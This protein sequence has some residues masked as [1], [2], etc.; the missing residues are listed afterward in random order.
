MSNYKTKVCQV[1]GK[2][3]R[4]TNGNQKYCTECGP[5]VDKS[6]FA[7]WCKAN[8]EKVKVENAKYYRLHGDKKKAWAIEYREANP[9][10]M[11]ER[12]SKYNK[13]NPDG[14]KEARTK[15]CEANPEKVKAK[16]AKHGAKRRDLAFLSLNSWFTGSDG[17]HLDADHVLFI[18]HMLHQSVSHNHRTGHG[19]EQINALAYAYAGLSSDIIND[20]LPFD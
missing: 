7:K 16:D 19:M 18:P 3:Y 5:M 4:P 15:W 1:C 17:H 11:K 10:K 13:K 8:P 2:E 9:E 6:R 12:T 20:T 14:A